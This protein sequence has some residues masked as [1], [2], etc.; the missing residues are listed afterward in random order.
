[1]AASS[2]PS[3]G[4]SSWVGFLVGMSY[5]P[6]PEHVGEARAQSKDELAERV[7][8]GIGLALL[9]PSDVPRVHTLVGREGLLG[10]ALRFAQRAHRLPSATLAADFLGSF[11]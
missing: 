6:L 4:G 11:R 3:D 7:H 10:I 1:M 2:S 5:S 8:R 9:N